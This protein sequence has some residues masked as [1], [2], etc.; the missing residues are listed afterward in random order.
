MQ[1]GKHTKF[2]SE[3]LKERNL[4]E[5]VGIDKGMILEGMLQKEGC[6]M[7]FNSGLL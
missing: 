5:D 4:L 2:W 3:N 7:G 1:G 6:R